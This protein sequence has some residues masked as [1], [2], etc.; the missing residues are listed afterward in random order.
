MEGWP[1]PEESASNLGD[2]SAN[3]ASVI[4]RTV[5]NG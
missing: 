3:T 1:R 2:S 5:R 4:H